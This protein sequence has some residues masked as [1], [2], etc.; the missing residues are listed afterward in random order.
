M[1]N[2]QPYSHAFEK[3]CLSIFES[4][5]PAYFASQEREAFRGFLNRQV[6]PYYYFVVY[7]E[8]EKIVACGGMKLEPDNHSAML[9]WDMVAS[10][11]QKQGIGTFLTLSR[12]HLLSQNPDIQ[13]VN[14]Y[15]SQYTYQFYKKFGFILQHVVPNGI[16]EGMDEYYMELNL[17]QEKIQ[18]LETSISKDFSSL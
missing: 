13:M 18:E 3:D 8:F 2:L 5:V 12:L 17:S 6:H 9:R 15:T 10:D 1:M 16:I 11:F 7:G 4:N 14:V